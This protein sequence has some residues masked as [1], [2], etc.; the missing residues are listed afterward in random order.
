MCM[1]LNLYL[2]CFG[3]LH[4]SAGAVL[5]RSMENLVGVPSTQGSFQWY[6][7]GLAPAEISLARKE[8]PANSMAKSDPSFSAAQ[9]NDQQEN[10]M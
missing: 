5:L 9:Q 2:R 6:S 7:M 3:I 10:T 4:F 8:W 1:L